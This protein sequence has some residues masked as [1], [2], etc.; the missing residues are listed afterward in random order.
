MQ[1]GRVDHPSP[2]QFFNKYKTFANTMDYLIS[3][4]VES[5]TKE[6]LIVIT[7]GILSLTSEI[8]KTK[9]FCRS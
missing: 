2:Y 7:G 8:I 3:S 4:A 9:K 6:G 1:F 5:E